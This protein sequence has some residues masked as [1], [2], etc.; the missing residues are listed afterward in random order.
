MKTH[1]VDEFVN[2]VALIRTG[3]PP[4]ELLGYLHAV[5][6]S[7]GRVREQKNGPRTCDLDILDYQLY[8]S[9]D[10]VLTLPHPLLNERDFVVKPLLEILPGH[11]LA[12]GTV[13]SPE[14]VTVGR[15]YRL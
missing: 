15:A 5:E 3:I 14:T 11:M 7:L 12:N 8:L 4:R 10:P 1:D 6:K 13:V 2:A 9:E